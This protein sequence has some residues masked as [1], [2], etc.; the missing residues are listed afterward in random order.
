MSHVLGE[1]G[2]GLLRSR[3]DVEIVSFPNLIGRSDFNELLRSGGGAAGAILGPTPFGELELSSSPGIQVVSRI[4]V[5]IDAIDVPALTRSRVPVMVT[6]TA[7]AVSIAEHTMSLLFALA[8]RTT[9][10][11]AIVREERWNDRM[12]T[13]P[14]ELMAKTV[15]VIGFGR[16]GRRVAAACR[17]F[18]MNVVVHDPM[19]DAGYQHEDYRFDADLKSAITTADFVTI[20]CPKTPET[21]GLLDQVTLSFMKKSAYLINTARGGI[22]DE[23]ALYHALE[24]GCIRGAALDVF[25]P[26]PPLLTNPLLQ[27]PNVVVT[28]H[29]AGVTEESV[30]RMAEAAA[31]NVLDVLDGHPCAQNLI[32]PRALVAV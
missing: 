14:T 10:T 23:A 29:L 25:D 6:S 9:E 11:Q 22:V 20:H 32:N 24:V 13:L 26:E 12:K 15:L 1:A 27:L 19:C 5:G 18:G 8:K 28:P 16:S 30:Q 7:N 17:F 21:I 31:Q 2:W 3:Q 4:G